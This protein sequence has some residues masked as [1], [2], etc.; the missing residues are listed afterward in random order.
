MSF[1][2]SLAKT[3]L[4]IDFIQREGCGLGIQVP[5]IAV[6]GDT[7]S[8][9]SSLLSAISNIEL[10]SSADIT[11][12]CP[13]SIHMEKSD[14]WSCSLRIIWADGDSPSNARVLADASD[15]TGAIADAQKEILDKE[16]AR[17]GQSAEVSK[18]VIDLTM[19]GPNFSDLTLIDL[20]GIV[21]THGKGESANLISGIDALMNDYLKNPRCVIL[22][23]V[24]ANV[25]YHNSTILALARTFDQTTER[26]L[27]VITKPDLI[28]DGAENSVKELLLGNKTDKFELGFHMVKCRSQR[29]NLDGMSIEESLL[30]EKLFFENRDPWSQIR[31]RNFFG[32]AQLIKKLS[33]LYMS[34]IAQKTPEILKELEAKSLLYQIELAG[35]G[36]NLTTT[37]ERRKFYKAIE[38]SMAEYLKYLDGTGTSSH[39]IEDKNGFTHRARVEKLKTEFKNAIH[40][41]RMTKLT[42]FNIGSKVLFFV[43]AVEYKGIIIGIAANKSFCILPTDRTHLHHVLSK[44]KSEDDGPFQLW[45]FVADA[46]DSLMPAGGLVTEVSDH[47][48]F[49]ITKFSK[50]FPKSEIIIDSSDSILD[51][52]EKNRTKELPTFLN[53]NVFNSQILHAIKSEWKPESLKLLQSVEKIVSHYF[54]NAM[55]PKLTLSLK[56][57]PRFL[58]QFRKKLECALALCLE[59]GQKAIEHFMR[60]ESCP[61][62]NNHYL[63]ENIQKL[64]QKKLTIQV[65][66]LIDP[67][68]GKV[69]GERILSLIKANENASINQYCAEEMVIILQAYGKVAEKRVC[70]SIAQIV[71]EDFIHALCNFE[72][73]FDATDEALAK[74]FGQSADVEERQKFLTDSIQQLN[75]VNEFVNGFCMDL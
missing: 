31:E 52:I 73:F 27:P 75:R 49:V 42:N 25:D 18:S 43:N 47:D 4:F 48:T 6:M 67:S 54:L 2:E 69:D 11:T 30:E 23:V 65:N 29:A 5:Q 63:N 33:K 7:S 50:T 32:I 26:T 10:P 72:D 40:D 36:A 60:M 45:D 64:R 17:S 38:T 14:N 28:D 24:P 37:S 70:D 51:L 59:R 22:A 21:R 16:K 19:K 44:D 12:R 8:G 56:V 66:Q 61:F 20:P 1:T 57:Y 35:L 74:L 34:M 46:G 55:L 62:T 39:V 53:A 13:T 71:E 68:D 9:K 3:R 41:S 15:V 58:D